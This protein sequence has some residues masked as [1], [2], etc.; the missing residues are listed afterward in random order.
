VVDYEIF[1]ALNG[2][3]ARNDIFEDLLRFFSVYAEVIFGVFLAGAFLAR[4]RWRSMNARHGVVAAAL[5]SILAIEAAQVI[6]GFWDRPRPYEAHA[7]HVFVSMS[8]DPSFPSD[9]ATVA[10][11]MA[12][13]IVL[14]N[15]R[16]GLVT[17]AMAIA[18]ALSRVVVGVHYPSDVLAGAV[19]GSAAAVLLWAPPIRR[20][21]HAASQ[22]L[23]ALYEFAVARLL[24]RWAPTT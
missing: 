23:S 7:A 24:A 3:A 12:V 11:A 21:L 16:L 8:P 4:G 2:L 22:R 14:R 5:A 18:V 19:L 15:R 13:S 10:F 17:V 20:P 6:S 9:H 1:K